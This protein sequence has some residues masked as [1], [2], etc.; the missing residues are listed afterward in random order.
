MNEKMRRALNAQLE[1]DGLMLGVC[2]G[3]GSFC[4]V[5]K[6][7]EKKTGALYGVAKVAPFSD[8][9]NIPSATAV[10]ADNRHAMIKETE[11]L[12]S[13]SREPNVVTMRQDLRTFRVQGKEYGFFIMEPLASMTESEEILRMWISTY[14]VKTVMAYMGFAIASALNAAYSKNNSFSHRDIKTS[15]LFVRLTPD[16][17]M[18]RKSF[19]LGDYG[20]S[21]S[22]VAAATHEVNIRNRQDPFRCPD[23]I[24]SIHSD[25]YSLACVMAYYGN[26]GFNDV[27]GSRS[28]ADYGKVGEIIEKM[29]SRNK[30]DRPSL[31]ECLKVFGEFISEYETRMHNDERVSSAAIQKLNAG[32]TDVFALPQDSVKAKRY[33]G[34]RDWLRGDRKSA[35]MNLSAEGDTI[36][37]FYLAS[38]DAQEGNR[39]A[40]QER[41]LQLRKELDGQRC[42]PVFDNILALLLSIGYPL[43][44]WEHATALAVLSRADGSF[45]FY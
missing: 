4:Q 35:R 19:K 3:A 29:L 34:V 32:K 31:A 40:A 1:R 41:L 28:T 30:S 18:T 8:D 7:Y 14:G 25:V 16:L 43:N 45:T 2:C 11:M 6:I 20:I 5:Y 33:C 37:R 27:P 21:N 39:K 26:I 15:N 9:E 42:H 36:S 23:A 10:V 44:K 13:L 38:I 22:S 24:Q 17:C 12:R